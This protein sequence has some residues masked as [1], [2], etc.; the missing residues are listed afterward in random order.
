MSRFLKIC[1]ICLG[2][3]G[4]V[5]LAMSEDLGWLPLL[6]FV[7]ISFLVIVMRWPS[8]AF[9]ALI[10]ASAMPHF[11]F[12]M[13]G[14]KARPEHIVLGLIVVTVLVRIALRRST[15]RLSGIDYLVV[16]FLT[17]NYVSSMF[18]SVRP[19]STL[20]WALL[21]N[22][23]I[24]PYFFLRFFVTDLKMARKI[25]NMVLIVGAA[26]AG[27]GVL[28]IV[29]YRIFGSTLGVDPGQYTS[30]PGTYGSQFEANL[31]GSYTAC[32]AAMFFVFFL[33]GEQRMRRWTGL[34]FLITA[35]GAL[36]SLS[37]GAVLSLLIACGYVLWIGY[38]GETS[39]RRKVLLC[40]KV[41][42]LVFAMAM[43]LAGNFL[44]ER[45]ATLDPTDVLAD[46]TSM[47]RLVQVASAVPDIL[48]HPILGNGADSFQLNFD[49]SD[50]VQE[51]DQPG[52][53]PG[54]LLRVVYDTGVVGFAIFLAIVIWT[55]KKLW[56]GIRLNGEHALVLTALLA[57]SLVYAI[58]FIASDATILAYSWIQLG[59]AVTTSMLAEQSE[60][61]KRFPGERHAS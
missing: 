5:W 4:M 22:F 58:A 31:F 7:S 49:W 16:A 38:G 44:K 60:L 47:V 36:V 56:Q 13:Y 25:L 21:Y 15:V 54:T 9:V 53:L 42:A 26:E 3:T 33:A 30:I 46:Q 40:A 10:C 29:L 27:Y 39:F 2:L 11:F 8:G 59:L 51:W 6:L 35:T 52:Y 14:W 32:S 12:E 45:F 1:T 34:G 24:L 28:C 17:I 19:S 37:R 57:G 23:A 41:S 43:L 50:Y 55:A 20:K 48:R 61:L 18:M